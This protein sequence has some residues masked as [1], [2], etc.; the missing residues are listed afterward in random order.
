MRVV[1]GSGRVS[2]FRQAE[3]EGH[4]AAISRAIERAR[5]EKRASPSF[6]MILRSASSTPALA[7]V[8]MKD[9]LQRARISAKVVLAKLEPEQELRELFTSLTQLAPRLQPSQLIR[10]TR[11]PR[12]LDAHEQVTYGDAICWSGDAMRR[13][14]DKRNALT[15]FDEAAPEMVR[16][17]L[18]AFEALWAASSLVPE[19]RL[20]GRSAPKP[21]GAYEQMQAQVAVSPHRPS[22]QAWPLVRH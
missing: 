20:I 3:L 8:R 12:L 14:A 2:D 6:T 15:L 21:S 11:N 13:D 18:L 7:V 19:R 16:F 10:W 4:V 5:S 9:Q 1:V 17:G 22:L